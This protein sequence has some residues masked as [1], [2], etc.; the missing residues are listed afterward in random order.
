ML[1]EG[2]HPTELTSCETGGLAGREGDSGGRGGQALF[3]P[4]QLWVQRDQGHAGNQ[5]FWDK[6]AHSQDPEPLAR[7]RLVCGCVS[8]ARTRGS[9][10][11]TREGREA[12]FIALAPCCALRP[13]TSGHSV[14]GMVSSSHAWSQLPSGSG[15]LVLTWPCG[16]AAH[17][18][19]HVHR[20]LALTLPSV[21]GRPT[22]PGSRVGACFPGRGA[23]R[24]E[25]PRPV[26][27]S[28][29]SHP[30][31]WGVCSPTSE[32]G[33]PAEGR[34]RVLLLRPVLSGQLSE[35][36]GAC[37]P[38]GGASWVLSGR[39]GWWRQ[40]APTRSILPEGAR[41]GTELLGPGWEAVLL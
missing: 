26:W 25:V 8:D 33:V 23:R 18:H 15:P 11:G 9:A 29:S 3:R 31:S 17:V 41:L 27:K 34:V 22:G 37:W 14:C 36:A 1:S 38:P 24:T 20:L 7:G 2:Q 19:V 13:V 6:E 40:K 4:S 21:N 10:V 5:R 32:G 16:Q 28:V 39:R 30:C 12:S 35:G